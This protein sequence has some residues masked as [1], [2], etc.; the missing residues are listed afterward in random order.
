VEEARLS[1]QLGVEL[2][3]LHRRP[4]IQRITRLQLLGRLRAAPSIHALPLSVGD[5]LLLRA[6][7][8]RVRDLASSGSLLVLTGVPHDPPRRGKAALAVALFGA[9]LVL[10]STGVLPLSV[11]GLGGVLAMVLT[12][13]VDG[14]RA[15]RV[16]WRVVL[17]IAAML[18][19]GLAMERSGAG[20]LV[21]EGV[22]RLGS[23]GGPRGVLVALALLTILLSAPMSNQAAALVVFPI[24][25][26]AAAHLHVDPRPF[27]I[28]VT[29][30]GSCSFMTPL[31]PAAMLVYGAGRYRFKDFTRVGTPLT[32]ALLVVIALLV[33]VFWPFER[34]ARGADQRRAAAETSVTSPDPDGTAAGGR[35]AARDAPAGGRPGP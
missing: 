17:L 31:E 9:A 26:S 35:A 3:A 1:H 23:A 11:A 2:L 25:L 29:L 12:G 15:L 32:L 34:A 20:A 16:E 33:P 10:G 18:A 28:A 5:V 19:L 22:A 27:A 7:A 8:E 6:P 21:G 13:C 30:A 14:R 4:A 24:A